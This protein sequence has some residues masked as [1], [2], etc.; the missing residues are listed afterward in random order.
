MQNHKKKLRG[1]LQILLSLLLLSLLL[2]QVGLDKVVDTLTHINWGWYLLAF[3]IFLLN[4]V[5]RAYRWFILLHSIDD[6]PPLVRLIYLYF[7]G[8]FANNFIPSGFGGDVIKVLN[9]RQHYG[10][11]TEALS[12]VVMERATGLMGSALIALAALIWNA[13]S[14][15]TQVELPTALWV[16]ITL[17]SVGIPAGFLTLRYVDLLGFLSKRFPIITRL[18]LYD[19]VERLM[20]TIRLYPFPVLMRALL[21]SLPFTIDLILVQFFV[22]Q[23]LAA[24]LP[25][26]I[27]PLFVPLIA[28][29]NLLPIAFNGLGVREGVYLFLFVPIGVPP[30]TAVAM[31]LAYYFL[32]FG[33]GLIGGLMYMLSSLANFVRTPRPENL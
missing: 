30:E 7:L 9:L 28:L 32:R 26:S 22:A 18:P 31:S 10:H 25:L 12:S 23:S 14:H 21:I 24:D 29:F 5:I 6:R 1:L 8:F 16:T 20:G 3:L 2:Y 13:L 27:F 15:T 33:A 17:I 4:I 19:K 11:G